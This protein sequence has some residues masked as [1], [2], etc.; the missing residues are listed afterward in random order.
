VYGANFGLLRLKP[1]TLDDWRKLNDPGYHSWKSREDCKDGAVVGQYG[2][3]VRLNR[4]VQRL[5]YLVSDAV[6]AGVW[7]YSHTAF[8]KPAVAGILDAQ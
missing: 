6:R 2:E 7:I 1:I 3:G 8:T 4:S 5:D